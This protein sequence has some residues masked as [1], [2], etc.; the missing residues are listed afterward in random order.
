VFEAFVL[1]CLWGKPQLTKYCEELRDTRGPYIT[2]DQ[3]L[4]RVYE[5]LKE[6]PVYRPEMQP[7][8]YRCD[9]FTPKAKKQRT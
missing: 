3:C 4:A 5:I 6:I 7:R 9:E 1:V 8:A 2:K